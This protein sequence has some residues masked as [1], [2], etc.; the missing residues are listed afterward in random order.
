MPAEV[1]ATPDFLGLAQAAVASSE[2]SE[3]EPE[4]A[5]QEIEAVARQAEPCKEPA[6]LAQEEGKQVV[7]QSDDEQGRDHHQ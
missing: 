6:P 5:D 4:A 1:V 7:V 2:R 3:A